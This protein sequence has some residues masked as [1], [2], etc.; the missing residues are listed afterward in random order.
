M[1]RD[2]L[3]GRNLVVIVVKT[4]KACHSSGSLSPSGNYPVLMLAIKI[5][6]CNFY[7]ILRFLSQK[8]LVLPRLLFPYVPFP[9][10]SSEGRGI[11]GK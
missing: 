9:A 6:I 2:S 1:A 3:I 7:L 4:T 11:S 8:I 10:R 5:E